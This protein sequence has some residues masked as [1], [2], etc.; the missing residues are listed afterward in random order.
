[1]WKTRENKNTEIKQIKKIKTKNSQYFIHCYGG[2]RL[3]FLP[4][5]MLFFFL[6]PESIR[7]IGA[8]WFGDLLP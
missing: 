6:K 8:V 3:P 2:G 7:P 5:V 4:K 1:M